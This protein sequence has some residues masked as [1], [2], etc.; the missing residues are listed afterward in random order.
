MENTLLENIKKMPKIELHM[1]LDGSIPIP[2]VMKK[3]NLKKNMC[4]NI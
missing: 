2:C 4:K 3:Y 1:H